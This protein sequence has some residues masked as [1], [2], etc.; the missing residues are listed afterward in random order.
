[1]RLTA[2]CRAAL[3]SLS[4]TRHFHTSLSIRTLYEEQQHLAQGQELAS[5]HEQEQQL[6]FEYEE[7]ELANFEDDD[8][9]SAFM[10]ANDDGKT[11]TTSAGHLAIRRDRRILYYLRLIENEVP[12]LVGK[13]SAM[14]FIGY[15]MAYSFAFK[16]CEDHTVHQRLLHPS[17]F[18]PLTMPAKNILPLR[19]ERSSFR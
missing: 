14:A 6:D 16:Y 3:S 1:M 15:S 17:L 11:D 12:K 19:S 13:L 2:Q 9:V 18:A 10:D 4:V 8:V 5:V 7:E